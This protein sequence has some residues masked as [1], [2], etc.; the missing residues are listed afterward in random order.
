MIL[1]LQVTIHLFPVP[2]IPHL[3]FVNLIIVVTFAVSALS[4]AVVLLT[5]MVVSGNTCYDT[6]GMELFVW[7]NMY[8]DS[9]ATLRLCNLSCCCRKKC[10]SFV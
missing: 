1:F 6:L 8:K 10:N 3:R 4:L 2:Q 5:D 9:P 7:W